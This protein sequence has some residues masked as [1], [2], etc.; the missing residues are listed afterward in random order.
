LFARTGW[1]VLS[2]INIGATTN[3]TPADPDRD[4]RAYV[5]LRRAEPTLSAS[6]N[7]VPPGDNPGKT[8]ISWSGGKVYVA[9]NGNDEVLFGQRH[10]GCNVATWILA[11]SNYEF[12]LYNSDHTELLAKLTVTTAAD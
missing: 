12:R 1:S 11:G 2:Q 5:L 4:E 6:P 9:M 7:P 10:E 3:S 8:T